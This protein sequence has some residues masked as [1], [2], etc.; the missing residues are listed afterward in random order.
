MSPCSETETSHASCRL[1]HNVQR[2]LMAHLDQRVTTAELAAVFGVSQTLI[3]TSFRQAY[4]TALYE[5]IR[6]QKMQTAARFLIETEQSVLEIAGRV[7]Y[8]NGS[9]F[10]QAFR[11]VTGMTPSQYR[12]GQKYTGD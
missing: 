10:A 4:G 8:A 5:Y 7:G 2:Y 9:K 11:N 1:A 6:Q 12:K 3:K